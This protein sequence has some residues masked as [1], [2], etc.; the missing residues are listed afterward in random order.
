MLTVFVL[1]GALGFGIALSQTLVIMVPTA[2]FAVAVSAVFVT[3]RALR[4]HGRAF[5]T[6]LVLFFSL[7]LLIVGLLFLESG[8]LPAKDPQ[9]APATVETGVMLRSEQYGVMVGERTGTALSD[10]V[11]V[12]TRYLGPAAT[13]RPALR[14]YR[15]VEWDPWERVLILPG[16]ED[17]STE[18]IPGFD[19]PGIHPA[20]SRLIMDVQTVLRRLR[21]FWTGPSGEERLFGVVPP[22]LDPYVIPIVPALALALVLAVVWAP[23]RLSRWPLLN[24]AFAFGW[25]RLVLAVPRLVATASEFPVVAARLPAELQ[26]VLVEL[27]WL[28]LTA[29]AVL[30]A[31]LLPSL[32]RWRHDMHY[33][34]NAS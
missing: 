18:N 23:A 5:P 20:V 6:I 12:D 21:Q 17:L 31:I 15:R 22:S 33:E 14:H 24:A 29:I 10:V 1:L 9:Q 13:Q 8:P 28:I 27:G 30:V 19:D 7:L 32:E 3:Q 25:L 16:D 4:R 11:V 26:P 2:L 34:E